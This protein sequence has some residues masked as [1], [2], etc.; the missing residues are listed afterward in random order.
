MKNSLLLTAI[1]T[2]SLGITVNA[3]QSVPLPP[4]MMQ[5]L[6]EKGIKSATEMDKA[7][8][9]FLATVGAVSKAADEI[10]K[11]LSC[12][13]TPSGDEE[14]DALCDNRFT[15]AVGN[16]DQAKIDLQWASDRVYGALDRLRNEVATKRFALKDPV[17]LTDNEENG[18]TIYKI[19]VSKSL[20]DNSK[21]AM[22]RWD[23][24]WAKLEAYFDREFKK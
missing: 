10:E 3:Q 13:L 8:G 14:A 21:S 1:A 6:A 16:F 7:Y 4:P 17:V 24:T 22:Q 19:R 9:N 5:I 20:K 15:R 12:K 23:A 2:L 11:T 18:F